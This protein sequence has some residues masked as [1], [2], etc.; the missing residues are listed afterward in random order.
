M[1]RIVPDLVAPGV[2]VGGAVPG[3][4]GVFSGTSA[5]AAITTGASA[6]L[7]Q[8]GIVEGHEFYMNAARVRALLVAGCDRLPNIQYPNVQWGYGSLNLLNSFRVLT[9]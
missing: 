9:L 7:L 2:N 3:G 1:P 8:W 6:I 5:A 4:H